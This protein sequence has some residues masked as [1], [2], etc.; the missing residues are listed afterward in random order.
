[1]P[2]VKGGESQQHPWGATW[3]AALSSRPHTKRFG[4]P[5]TTSCVTSLHYIVSAGLSILI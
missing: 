3:E 5:D 4:S 2:L 1:M